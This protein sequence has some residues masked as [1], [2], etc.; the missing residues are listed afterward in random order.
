MTACSICR[1]CRGFSLRVNILIKGL[2]G[3][4]GTLRYYQCSVTTGNAAACLAT[5]KQVEPWPIPA[6]IAHVPHAGRH[7][8]GESHHAARQQSAPEGPG[9]AAHRQPHLA[10]WRVPQDPAERVQ[11]HH[12]ICCLVGTWSNS[13]SPMHV[14]LSC[15]L[16]VWHDRIASRSVSCMCL[17]GYMY[18]GP[19]LVV[20]A[21]WQW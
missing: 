20:M 3:R 12:L 16:V 4:S 13:G 17:Q 8:H 21:L 11:H 2:L 7:L 10:D 5:S 9:L 18:T 6:L 19:M 15:F 14:L 1:G